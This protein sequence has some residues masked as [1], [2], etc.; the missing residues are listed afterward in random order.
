MGLLQKM[1]RGLL[2]KSKK[3]QI[4]TGLIMMLTGVFV[5]IVLVVIFV[6]L[7]ET[8]IDAAY[9]ANPNSDGISLLYDFKPV[10][11]ILSAILPL[12][13]FGFMGYRAMQ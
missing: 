13:A 10:Y 12:G 2:S 4:G 7:W 6:P 8:K 5:S 11:G 1:A 9:T 3:G